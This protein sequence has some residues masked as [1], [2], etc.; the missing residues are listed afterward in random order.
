VSGT[1]RKTRGQLPCE[2]A[3]RLE[4]LI[5]MSDLGDAFEPKSF[6]GL[7]PTR[8]PPLRRSGSA[9][10]RPPAQHLG[11][12]I[13]ARSVSTPR[14]TWRRRSPTG[15]CGSPGWWIT[16]ASIGVEGGVMSAQTCPVRMAH[17]TDRPA[18]NAT[19]GALQRAP[20]VSA[21]SAPLGP[22]GRGRLVI[23]RGPLL[24][25]CAVRRRSR[26]RWRRRR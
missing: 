3:R 5:G 6:P 7:F 11:S 17:R 19:Y 22:S 25:P 10:A 4:M 1:P 2:V 26:R 14:W 13:P 12:T 15:A 24:R 9:S 18:R 20:G 23:S 16:N 21:P 8:S